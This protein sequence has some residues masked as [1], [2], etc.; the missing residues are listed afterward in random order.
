MVTVF[1]GYFFSQSAHFSTCLRASGLR[2]DLSKSKKIRSP[3]LATRSSWLPG[4][5]WVVVVVG[6]AVVPPPVAPLLASSLVEH[7]ARKTTA[8]RTDIT[9]VKRIFLAPF[10]GLLGYS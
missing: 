2:S 5:I 10:S 9:E 4:R 7:A 3:T 6:A 1:C 8:A